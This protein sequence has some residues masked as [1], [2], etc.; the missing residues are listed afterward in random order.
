LREEVYDEEEVEMMVGKEEGCSSDD[1][2]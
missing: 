1:E 2:Q